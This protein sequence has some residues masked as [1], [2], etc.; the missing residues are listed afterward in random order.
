ML[1][2][3][4]LIIS[5]QRME[6]FNSEISVTELSNSYSFIMSVSVPH[7]TSVFCKF[8]VI[9]S[10]FCKLFQPKLYIYAYFTIRLLT[11]LVLLLCRMTDLQAADLRPSTARC[12]DWSRVPVSAFGGYCSY[13]TM[14]LCAHLGSLKSKDHWGFFSILTL[15]LLWHKR[16]STEKQY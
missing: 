13:L 15:Y 10:F 9:L 2:C 5:E 8:N 6:P 1:L 16:I 4:F 7:C 3:L 12:M 11:I 14:W